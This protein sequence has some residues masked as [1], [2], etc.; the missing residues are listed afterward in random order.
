M[1]TP[2]HSFYRYLEAAYDHFNGALFNGQLPT[3]LLTVQREKNIM[4]Y[5]S[6]NRWTDPDGQV[7]HELAVNPAYFAR[8]NLMEVLQTIV[9]E[10]AHNWQ[11]CFGKPSRGGYHNKEWAGKMERIG[12]MPSSTGRPGGRKTGQRMSDY[13]IRGGAFERAAKAFIR[14]SRGLPWVDRFA[15]LTP[16]CQPRDED[17]LWDD[18]Q[19]NEAADPQIS[20]DPVTALL[21]APIREL[22]QEL[23]PDEQ[24]QAARKK[25]KSRYTCEHCQTNVW[26]KPGLKLLCGVCGDPYQESEAA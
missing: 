9:H 19:E 15:S 24:L 4:G 6:A 3:C 1:K 20:D 21:L 26:G 25:V 7:V 18:S 17:Y 22:F 10:M 11:H 13:P 5:F 12:L 14:D 23:V 2:T 16:S 8:H